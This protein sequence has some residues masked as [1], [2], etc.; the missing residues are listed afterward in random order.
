MLRAR[1]HLC[2]YEIVTCELPGPV[3]ACAGELWPGYVVPIEQAGRSESRTRGEAGACDSDRCEE[4]GV[5]RQHVEPR[6]GCDRGEGSSARDAVSRGAARR[7]AILSSL[8]RYERDRQ[9][10]ILG[11]LLPG[12]GGSRSGLESND[13]R[14]S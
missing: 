4:N 5:G 14:T 2:R 10:R 8:L 3:V 9:A 7:R 1:A 13:T 12:T 11:V 6:L